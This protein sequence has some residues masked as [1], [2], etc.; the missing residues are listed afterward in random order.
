MFTALEL[1]SVQVPR[2]GEC[3]DHGASKI[4]SSSE[5]TKGFQKLTP[6]YDVDT[7]AYLTPARAAVMLQRQSSLTHPRL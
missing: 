6:Q 5:M 1:T 4:R 2:Y 3:P 7:Q